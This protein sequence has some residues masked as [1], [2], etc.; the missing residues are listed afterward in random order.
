MLVVAKLAGALGEL[1][2]LIA[3]AECRVGTGRQDPSKA[4]EQVRRIG[5]AV[6]GQA[7]VAGGFLGEVFG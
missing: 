7:V 3:V 1:N 6:K 4:I 5:Q 2:G